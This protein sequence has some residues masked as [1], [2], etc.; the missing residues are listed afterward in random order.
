MAINDFLLLKKKDNF[1]VIANHSSTISNKFLLN[2]KPLILLLF[3]QLQLIIS[4]ATDH[5]Q[6]KKKSDH[7]EFLVS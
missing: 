2:A 7:V 4:S 3:H 5:L 6:K 1:T